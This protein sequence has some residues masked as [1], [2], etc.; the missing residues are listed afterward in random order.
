MRQMK[1]KITDPAIIDRL[2]DAAPVGR[3]A[4]VGPEG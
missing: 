1:K 4:T 3:L 2:L